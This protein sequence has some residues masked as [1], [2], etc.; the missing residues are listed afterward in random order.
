MRRIPNPEL[1]FLVLNHLAEKYQLNQMRQAGEF[2]LSTGVYCLTKAFFDAKA[3]VLPTETEIMLF[4]VGLGLQDILTP[5]SAST[6]VFE[7]DGVIYRPDFVLMLGDEE[8]HELKTTRMSLKTLLENLPE[9][10]V[11]YIAGGCYM[12]DVLTYNL[13]TLLLMGSYA[14][15]FPK[16]YSETL[17]FVPDELQANWDRILRRKVVY[18]AA[19]LN[20]KCPAPFK[21][22]KD[23][24]C[25]NCRYKL[26]CDVVVKLETRK[27][28]EEDVK[29][30]WPEE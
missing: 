5:S 13:S 23:W 28:A 18:D 22:C 7:K 29:T 14:P 6:P 19:M 26:Q 10:W 4:A 2:H 17:E 15:P 21:Y 27:Q 11:E 3:P 24:E 30:L 12:R 25:K 16:I 9:T 8:Y 20:D 1:D